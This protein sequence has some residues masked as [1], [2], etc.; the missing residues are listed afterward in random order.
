MIDGLGHDLH[1]KFVPD[2]GHNLEALFLQALKGVWRSTRLV[3]TA[4]KELSARLMDSF[5]DG[6]CL[7]ARLNATRAGDD[8]QPRAPDGRIGACKTDD[9]IFLF[10]IAANQLIRLGDADHF[11]YARQFIER[12]CARPDPCCR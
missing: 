1:A 11:L 10:H 12:A 4:A 5:G 9:R 2:L 3:G 7:F 6:E 8:R